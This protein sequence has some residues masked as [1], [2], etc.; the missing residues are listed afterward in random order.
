MS[1]MPRNSLDRA[2]QQLRKALNDVA[3]SS[4]RELEKAIEDKRRTGVDFEHQA[5]KEVKTLTSRADV[6]KED[7][8]YLTHRIRAL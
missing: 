3:G 2:M 6:T 4:Y 7:L 8:A 1:Y 5:E